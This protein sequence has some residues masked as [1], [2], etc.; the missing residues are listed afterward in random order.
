MRGYDPQTR[1]YYE[2]ALGLVI[3]PILVYPTPDQIKA[4]L[5][6]INSAFHDFPFVPDRDTEIDTYYRPLGIV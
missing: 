1:L 5:E 2:P 6:T 3:P 4:A